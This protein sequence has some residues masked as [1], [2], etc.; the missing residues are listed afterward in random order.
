MVNICSD[1]SSTGSFCNPFKKAGNKEE[2]VLLFQD[3]IK[4]SQT[5]TEESANMFPLQ[6]ALLLLLGAI[7][8]PNKFP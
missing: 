6:G 8:C 1:A 4:L 7:L 5:A 2:N 3:S